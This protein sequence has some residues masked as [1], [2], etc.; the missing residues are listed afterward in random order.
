MI[1]V[2]IIAVLMF[3]L[4]FGIG[5]ILNMLLKTTWLPNYMYGLLVI[6]LIV[7]FWSKDDGSL[8]TTLAAFAIPDY[9]AFIGGLA[10][11]WLSGV[12]IRTL[13]VK[14]YKMF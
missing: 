4:M 12:T 1:Q 5:F 2:A 13:R 3:V 10:G 7:W 6:G 11:A 8:W 9:V 14:G